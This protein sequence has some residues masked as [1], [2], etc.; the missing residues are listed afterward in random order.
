MI[1]HV[2]SSCAE[3]KR[4]APPRVICMRT[5]AHGC[6]PADAHDR[7]RGLAVVDLRRPEGRAL[8]KVTAEK[9]RP[10]R[11]GRAGDRWRGAIACF[12]QG[13]DRRCP[14]LNDV[15]SFSFRRL[16]A[17]RC[18]MRLTAVRAGAAGSVRRRE[19]LT[20]IVCASPGSEGANEHYRPQAAP[21]AGLRSLVSPGSA[22]RRAI[23][24]GVRRG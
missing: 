4:R 11:V 16:G 19:S 5:D 13:S 8:R 9:R 14:R 1:S 7:F 12:G 18:R 10:L 24:A 6:A 20:V 3:S 2:A 23:R 21:G 15:I 17:G 22:R